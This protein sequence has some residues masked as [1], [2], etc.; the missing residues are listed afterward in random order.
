MEQIPEDL[1]QRLIEF[2]QPHEDE[3]IYVLV[4]HVP[5]PD[6]GQ[7][8]ARSNRKSQREGRVILKYEPS[9]KFTR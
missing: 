1:I 3:I 5:R 2:V 9:D 7:A 6:R 4:H 8:N